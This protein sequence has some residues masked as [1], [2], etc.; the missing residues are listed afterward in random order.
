MRG[1]TVRSPRAPDGVGIV[2]FTADFL[3]PATLAWRLEREWGVM[4][5][6][7]L[8][9]APGCHRLLGSLE[10]GA[11]RFSLGWASTEEDVDRALEGVEAVVGSRVSPARPGRH[12]EG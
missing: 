12:A 9:C 7:G 8:H 2:T 10:T 3:D 4:G 6:A 5:R 11:L 1:V